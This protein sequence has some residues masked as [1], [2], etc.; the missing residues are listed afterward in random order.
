VGAGVSG[1][2]VGVGAGVS[3]AGVSGVGGWG[4]GVLA[5]RVCS[6][7]RQRCFFLHVWFLWTL[8]LCQWRHSA[9]CFACSL[10]A[11][12]DAP[13]AACASAAPAS[14]AIANA[15]SP[16]SAARVT[17]R[18]SRELFPVDEP[19][20]GEGGLLTVKSPNETPGVAPWYV[21]LLGRH[22]KESEVPIPRLQQIPSC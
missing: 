9:A 11:L 3:G 14:G 7:C 16:T 15:E 6:R 4:L 18:R 13:F 19:D 10:A 5:C 20:S 8:H 17:P 2:G 21:G 12:V 1:E 22:L